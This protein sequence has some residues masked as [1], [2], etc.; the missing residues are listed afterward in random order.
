[1]E[2]IKIS[3]TGRWAEPGQPWIRQIHV[4]EGQTLVVGQDVS[5]S[6]AD[7]MVSAKAAIRVVDKSVAK[8]AGT[9]KPAAKS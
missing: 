7:S 8:T 4:E 6:M 1:M 3:K 5:P 9:T 2:R